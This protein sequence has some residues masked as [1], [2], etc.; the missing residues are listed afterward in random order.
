MDPTE[1]LKRA[2]RQVG[3]AY[4]AGHLDRAT[5]DTIHRR[6]ARIRRRWKLGPRRKRRLEHQRAAAAQVALAQAEIRR[7]G[8]IIA[9]DC[10]YMTLGPATQLGIAVWSGGR[11]TTR[12]YTTPA[13]DKAVTSPSRFGRERQVS[14]RFLIKLARRL[15]RIDGVHVFHSGEAEVSRLGFDVRHPRHVDTAQITHGVFLRGQTP[16]VSR[17]CDHLGIDPS[18][19]HN[20]GN[21]ARFTLEILLALASTPI[22]RGRA[23]E[24]HAPQ[25]REDNAIPQQIP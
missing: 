1:R 7:R 24:P 14:A 8:V 23:N 12:T 15:Y 25:R 21:D 4:Q 10:E 2:S 19:A 3:L 11:I 18:G 17:L 22:T 9:Y 6:I 16:S 5:R 13:Y 20:A